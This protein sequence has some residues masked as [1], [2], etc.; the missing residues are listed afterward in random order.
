VVGVRQVE[1]V[2]GVRQV[3]RVVGVRQVDCVVGV[4]QVERV[5]GGV[6]VRLEERNPSMGPMVA[7][8]GRC[9]PFAS[10]ER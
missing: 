1:R 7:V 9:R 5:A 2:V 8:A 10:R 6:I 3:E 4:R